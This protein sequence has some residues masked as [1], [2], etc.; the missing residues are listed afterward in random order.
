MD[1]VSLAP[2]A[3]NPLDTTDPTAGD[4]FDQAL[5]DA[6]VTGGVVVGSQLMSQIL[7]TLSNDPDTP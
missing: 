7:E 2:G 5:G 3:Q 6:I 4:A 1:P